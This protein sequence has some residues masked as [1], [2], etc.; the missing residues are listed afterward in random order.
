[1]HGIPLHARRFGLLARAWQALVSRCRPGRGRAVR[2]PEETEAVPR[3]QH[4]GIAAAEG[5]WRELPRA[6]GG[7][8]RG[9][10]TEH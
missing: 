10:P 6:D 7:R 4:P 1:M 5:I 8:E 2:E 9:E 3:E